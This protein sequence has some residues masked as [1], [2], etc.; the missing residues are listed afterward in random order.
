M[1]EG[2]SAGSPREQGFSSSLPAP[3]TPWPGGAQ[4]LPAV[5][6]GAGKQRGC[7]RGRWPGGGW[8]GG[9]EGMRKAQEGSGED[10]RDRR[11]PAAADPRSGHWRAAEPD[12]PRSEQ[13]A[14]A[15]RE[16][17]GMGEDG[18][19]SRMGNRSEDGMGTGRGSSA[20]RPLALWAG[21]GND[22]GALPRMRNASDKRPAA[23]SSAL[24]ALPA[25][26][27]RQHHQRP[28]APGGTVTPQRREMRNG[29]SLSGERRQLEKG[30]FFREGMFLIKR[31]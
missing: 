16:S 14:A 15:G 4:T 2:C 13:G 30:T 23:S 8:S 27:S 10:R 20:E 21:F 3:R 12:G 26:Q 25:F 22:P 28:S 1:W 9:S 29:R 11:L 17:C 7:R 18:M 5:P 6:G 24:P 31:K 19:E